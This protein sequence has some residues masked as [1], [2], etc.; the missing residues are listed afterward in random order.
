MKH[1]LISAKEEIE[2]AKVIQEGGDGMDA[3]IERF[4]L[5]NLR[6]VL[7]QVSKIAPNVQ[8]SNKT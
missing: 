3:A 4:L 5:A 7:Y 8:T 6:L 2:L 1:K